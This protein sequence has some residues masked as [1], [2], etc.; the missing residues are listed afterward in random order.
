MSGEVPAIFITGG[1]SGIG[2]AVAQRFAR[3]GWRVGLADI[4]A[5]GMAETAASIPD[6]AVTRHLLDVRDR[7]AWDGA[8]AEFAEASGGRIDVLMNNAGIAVSGP[9]AQTSTED[10]ERIVAI[11][12]MGVVHGAHAGYRWLKATPGS[13]LLNTASAAAIWGTP[14][15]AIYSATKAGVKALC[16]SLDAE[17]A[18]DAIK[19][20]CLMP[21]FID[22]PLLDEAVTGTNLQVRDRVRA[23]GLEFTPL[24]TVG[25][26]AWQAVRGDALHVPVGKTAKRLR[27]ATRWLPG[28]LRARLRGSGLRR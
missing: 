8:L 5:D 14:G 4:N 17:W 23:M 12:L 24:E 21:G 11:N 20:R 6:G 16:E 25:E 15:A 28:R 3:E 7:T 22:T 18:G 10:F 27:F 2:R 13:C 26:A 19:V 1:A 9:F